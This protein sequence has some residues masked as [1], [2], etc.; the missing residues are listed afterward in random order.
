MYIFWIES[1]KLIFLWVIE[2]KFSR[3]FSQIFP[4]GTHFIGVLMSLLDYQ[5][6]KDR[7]S[8]QNSH[9]LVHLLCITVHELIATTHCMM[10][11]FLSSVRKTRQFQGQWW[12]EKLSLLFFSSTILSITKIEFL[13]NAFVFYIPLEM[14]MTYSL[15][16]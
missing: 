4:S 16:Y 8:L 12:T 10:A 3:L 13:E 6:P 7:P 9:Y 11:T 2:E 15:H 1:N 14:E 5:S